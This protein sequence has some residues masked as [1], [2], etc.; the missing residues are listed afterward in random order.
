MALE[1]PLLLGLSYLVGRASAKVKLQYKYD[2]K[3][4]LEF[5]WPISKTDEL[6]KSTRK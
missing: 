2:R 1:K 6:I 3:E 5:M 4:D